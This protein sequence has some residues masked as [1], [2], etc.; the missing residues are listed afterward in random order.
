MA[1]SV[2]SIALV[3]VALSSLAPGIAAAGNVDAVNKGGSLVITGDGSPNGVFLDPG[4]NPD[5]FVVTPF[6]GTTVN[7]FPVPAVISGITRNVNV[8][9]DDGDDDLIVNDAV[10]PSRLLVKLGTG[11]DTFD[12]TDGSVVGNASVQG[13]KGADDI[14]I[15]TIAVGGN[16]KIKSEGD[17]DEI[18]LD[19]VTVG[20]NTTITSGDGDDTVFIGGSSQLNGRLKVS[21]DRGTDAVTLDDS[22]VVGKVG[23]SLGTEDDHVTAG[24]MSFDDP[25]VFDGGSGTDTYTDDGGNS[26]SVPLFLKKIEIIN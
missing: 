25:V 15:S 6:F 18:G 13:G 5:E 20:R 10:V 11:N 23:V 12:Y 9:L 17:A 1:H 21:T 26:F 24:A 2:R 14:G 16:L 19:L 3:L 22:T 4:L 8:D 7:G